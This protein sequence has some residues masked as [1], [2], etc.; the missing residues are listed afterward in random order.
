MSL[1]APFVTF[2]KMND[3][4]VL[5]HFYSYHNMSFLSFPTSLKIKMIDNVKSVCFMLSD[6]FWELSQ[7]CHLWLWQVFPYLTYLSTSSSNQS[8]TLASEIKLFISE[9]SPNTQI[10]RNTLNYHNKYLLHSHSGNSYRR[11]WYRMFFSGVLVAWLG[12]LHFL[13]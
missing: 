4:N 3:F 9:T 1:V 2:K 6:N 12:S 13:Q 8:V 11:I 10:F 5:A 7:K